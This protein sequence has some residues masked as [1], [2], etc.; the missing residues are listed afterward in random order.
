MYL[1]FTRDAVPQ[2]YDEDVEFTIG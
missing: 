2:I 1:R